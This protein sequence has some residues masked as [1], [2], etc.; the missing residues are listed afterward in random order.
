[1]FNI[2]VIVV[3]LM[4]GAFL[5]AV[6]IRDAISLATALSERSGKK[7]KNLPAQVLEKRLEQ[8]VRN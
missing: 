7:P 8:F 3:A 4:L 2:L 1:M 6:M 5:S